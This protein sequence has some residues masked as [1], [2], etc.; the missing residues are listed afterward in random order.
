MDTQ[1][2]REKQAAELELTLQLVQP[3]KTDFHFFVNE[4]QEPFRKAAELEVREAAPPPTTQHGHDNEHQQRLHDAYLFNSNL[5][6]RLK[7]AWEHDVPADERAGYL[8]KEEA[9]RR[10][11]MEEDT[12]ASRHCAT[13]TSRLSS[14]SPRKS[15]KSK[16]HEEANENAN[17]RGLVNND[18]LSLSDEPASS[19]SPHKKN[20][21]EEEEEENPSYAEGEQVTV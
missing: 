14:P 1:A 15:P 2:E 11:F 6:A 16:E 12:I 18:K 10:R 19:S 8:K 7:M 5:N 13:L 21:V 20:K 17:K 9:D 4:K 3:I